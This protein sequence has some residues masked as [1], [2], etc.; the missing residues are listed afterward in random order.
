MK[1]RKFLS[2]FA[3]I[4]VLFLTGEVLIWNSQGI[5]SFTMAKRGPV[6]V[7]A[8][9]YDFKDDLIGDIRNSLEDIQKENQGTIEYVF[10]D[11][12]SD[13]VI[14]N[15]NVEKVLN[16][17]VD[18]ILLNLV[19]RDGAQA[20]INKIK[21]TNTPVV[22]F[23]R[24]PTTTLPIQ[25]YNRAI[26]V[27]TEPSQA[28]TL[29]GR[30]IVDV[31]N[32]SKEYIDKNNNN[33][34]EYVMLQGERDNTE[35]IERTRYSIS[36]IEGAGINTRRIALEVCDWNEELAYNATKKLL[37]KHGNQI[38]A[39]IANDDTMAIGAI[40]ALQE[41]GY[42]K[43]DKSKTIV[44]I[45]VDITPEAKAI[46]E[47]GNMLGSVSQNPREYA[48]VLH[49]SGINLI[50]KRSPIYGTRY[51]LDSTGTA[52]RIPQTEYL[53]NNIFLK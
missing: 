53:Y 25:S 36:T 41:Q 29:Q 22:L 26:Y 5:S 50:N 19:N 31:W 21:V 12:K 42:N 2:I 51:Q 49:S 1:I 11:S 44:V 14:Q 17:G 18:L 34:I 52:I 47:K 35:A 7:A 28:G 46:I 8:L 20:I 13:E 10:Y 43:G 45:G 37:L 40:K 48:D 39:I 16:E 3:I 32:S 4:T 33:I 9:L 24:E 27:G 38:E 23:N 30:M 6:K 15:Q